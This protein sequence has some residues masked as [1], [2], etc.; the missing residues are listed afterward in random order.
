MFL[1]PLLA[2]VVFLGG[3]I[4]AQQ[5]Q[6]DS[7]TVWDGVYT[8]AQASRGRTQF[9]ASCRSCHR[10]EPYQGDAFMRAWSGSDVESLFRQVR[11]T[12]PTTAPASLNEGAYLDIVAYLLQM[13]AFPVGSR[14]LSPSAIKNIRIIGQDGSDR[15]P[16]FAL[17]RTVGCLIRRG[18]AQWILADATEPVRT[19]NPAGSSDA[20]LKSSEAAAAGGR[21][22]QLLNIY[23]S[24]VPYTGHKVE[25]KGFLI[26]DPGGDRINVTS[27]Q[28]IASLC[29]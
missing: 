7:Q 2:L 16:D 4:S 27:L 13:N 8:E 26:R 23:P 24:P 3:V 6:A 14:E 21:T 15:V 10:A 20:E 28:S 1:V 9:E 22:F 11:T 19:R 29:K 17:V 18:D 5:A 25:A 12:M